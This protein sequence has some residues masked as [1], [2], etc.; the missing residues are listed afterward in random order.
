M[1]FYCYRITINHPFYGNLT[2]IGKHQA[3]LPNN[4]LGSCSYPQYKNWVGSHPDWVSKEI[5][6]CY[7]TAEDQSQ[8]ETK[9]ILE[10]LYAKGSFYN[11]V[12]KNKCISQ[13]AVRWLS[14]FKQGTCL[15]AHA[16]DGNV[17]CLAASLKLKACGLSKKQ[18]QRNKEFNLKGHSQEARKKAVAHTDYK[19][20]N[21]SENVRK[22]LKSRTVFNFKHLH[23]NECRIKAAKSRNYMEIQE[24]RANSGFTTSKMNRKIEVNGQVYLGVTSACR[25]L[26]H[27]E[28]NVSVNAKF[29]KGL[30]PVNHHGFKFI[31]L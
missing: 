14:K 28:W 22:R 10:E 20:I 15:N 23:T 18:Q 17:G 6:G 12:G 9:F 25:S 3:E 7:E 4:Y 11:L 1:T 24:K 19:K 27:P 5:L 16:S 29:K 21:S 26:G 2:Y 13:A 30:N 8:A 31:L